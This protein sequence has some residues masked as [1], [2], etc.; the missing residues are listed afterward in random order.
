MRSFRLVLKSIRKS[1]PNLRVQFL[2]SLTHPNSLLQ[3]F[4]QN[5]SS[6]QLKQNIMLS[7]NFRVYT[8]HPWRCGND[9][10]NTL[11][12]GRSALRIHSGAALL[13]PGFGSPAHMSVVMFAYSTATSACGVQ[14]KQVYEKSISTRTPRNQMSQKNPG[15]S[16]LEPAAP[17]RQADRNQCALTTQPSPHRLTCQRAVIP[18]G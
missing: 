15:K 16:G 11:Y 13:G 9:T 5:F 1:T 2:I 4:I 10:S 17:I 6:W 8:L 12:S 14:Q 7:F 18:I 3:L